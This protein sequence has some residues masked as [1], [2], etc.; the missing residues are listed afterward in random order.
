MSLITISKLVFHE[1]CLSLKANVFTQ[2]TQIC[3]TRITTELF[4][5]DSMKTLH[6][7]TALFYFLFM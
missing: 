7:Y 1:Q 4:K 3:Q 2:Y 5:M 6:V